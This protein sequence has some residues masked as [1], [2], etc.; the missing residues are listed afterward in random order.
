MAENITGDRQKR[1]NSL[2][3]FFQETEDFFRQQELDRNATENA[4]QHILSVIDTAL[5]AKDYD[6]LLALIPYIETGDGY[7]A[8]KYIGKTHR[9]LRILNIIALEG[10]YHKTLFCSGCCNAGVLW[11]KYML[12]MFAFRRLLFRLSEESVNEAVSWLQ[13]HPLSHFAAYLIASGDLLIPDQA[14]YENLAAIYVDEWTLGDIQQFFTLT[15]S[16]P[17][18]TLSGGVS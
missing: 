16:L 10:K 13:S 14:F 3:D 15:A 8:F 18:D 11:E 6:A 7:L 17:T 5:A 2:S 9:V 12:T 1:W 4:W